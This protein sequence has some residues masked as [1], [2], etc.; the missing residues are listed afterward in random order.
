V[1]TAQPSLWA[2]LE[3]SAG[4]SDM[5]VT[6][7]GDRF[8]SWSWDGWR[9]RALELAGGLRALGVRPGDRVAALLVNSADACAAVLGVWMAGGCLLSMPT[10]ARGMAPDRYAAQLR[11]IVADAEPALVLTDAA[12]AGPLEA[13]GLGAR[14]VGFQDVRG[15]PL[16]EPELAAPDD[17]VFVQ[18]SSGSTTDPKGCV[19]TA[20]AIAWQLSASADAVAADPAVDTSVAWLPMSHDMGLFGCVLLTYWTGHRLVLGTPQRFLAQPHTWLDDCAR[21]GATI[22]ATPNFGLDIAARVGARRP[23]GP[24]PMRRLVVGGDRVEPATLARAAEA[25]GPERVRRTALAPA[26]GLAEAV[27]TVTM[28]PEG[29]GARIAAV[30]AAALAD[31]EVRDPGPGARPVALTSAGPPLPGIE[32]SVLGGGEDRTGEIVVRSPALASG[33]LGAPELSAERF[34]REGLRTGDIGFIR[35][36]E[37]YVTGRVDDLMSLGGRNVYARDLELA[38]GQV[39]GVRPGACAVVDVH[40]S[41]ATAQ[42]VA[43][44]EPQDPSADLPA[45][46]RQLSAA[47]REAAGVGIDECLFLPKGRLPK[48]PSGKVQRFRCRELAGDAN[49]YRRVSVKRRAAARAGG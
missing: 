17:A 30:D 26:Y 7:E 39:A 41:G 32:L 13:A 45:L 11:R 37:L 44:V 5:L 19:L 42:V 33:Y 8:A 35:D 10:I 27:L 40:G 15:A 12:L 1:I 4:R 16:A 23:S 6:W 20:R 3:R 38:L 22:T 48:T 43:L 25:L 34:T 31:G 21:F 47:T 49:G 29:E 18:Y 9:A 2:P 28:A 14:V 36:G 46:A 24:F